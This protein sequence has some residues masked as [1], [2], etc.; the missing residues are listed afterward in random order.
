MKRKVLFILI[1]FIIMLS[2]GWTSS[3]DVDETNNNVLIIHS[4]YQH[5]AWTYGL[6]QGIERNLEKENIDYYLEYL[7]EHRLT[8]ERTYR[9]IY[10]MMAE[11]YKDVQFDCI[12]IADN[13]ALNFMK[14]Y[15]DELFEGV[16]V[17]LVGINNMNPESLFIDDITGVAQ[18]AD[19]SKMIRLIETLHPDLS[20]V[21][22]AGSNNFTSKN[23]EASY[24]AAIESLGLEAKT[25]YVRVEYL[26]DLYEKL[27]TY[28]ENTVVIVTSLVIDK[29][30]T[31]NLGPE[32][33]SNII[34]ESGL[35]V[36]VAV[37]VMMGSE[38]EGAVGG[39]IVDGGVH[40][41]YAAQMV[42][43]I[44]QG[45][46]ASDIPVMWEPIVTPEFNYQR[47]VQ[48]GI[49]RDQLPVGSIVF[50]EPDDGIIISHEIA[51]VYIVV[52]VSLTLMLLVMV[53]SIIRRKNAERA[54]RMN[55]VELEESNT[56]LIKK[57]KEIDFLLNN[58]AITN[59]NNRN[60]FIQ[61]MH[62]L[63]NSMDCMVMY[64][65]HVRN[66]KE[67]DDAYGYHIGDSAR[68]AI[69][70]RIRAVFGEDLKIFA[71]YYDTF[72]IVDYQENACSFVPELIHD[73]E[74]DLQ[75][76]VKVI[77]Y[78][79][80]PKIK[81]GVVK[82]ENGDDGLEL[83]KKADIAILN[84]LQLEHEIAAFYDQSFHKKLE[85][86]L[87]MEKDLKAAIRS[88]AFELYYQPQVN[89]TNGSVQSCEALI[90]WKNADG[91]NVSPAV[92]IPLAEELGLIN[93]I[94]EW[95]FHEACTTLKDWS[96]RGI[97]CS[98]SVNVS[99]KQIVPS[100][101]DLLKRVLKQY[102]ISPDKLFIEI[103]ETA[104]MDDT[105]NNIRILREVSALGIGIALDDFGIGHSSL[106]YIKD[107]PINK[108]KIDKSFIDR[109]TDKE[110]LAIVKA[111]YE[112]GKVF[113]YRVIAEGVETYEQSEIVKKIGIEEIQG[114][115]YSKALSEPS[116]VEYYNRVK[117]KNE[118]MKT[119]V[120]R[121]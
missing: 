39:Y 88:R 65:V 63:L 3:A 75:D 13:F 68:L 82:G 104:V 89:C 44:M 97:N 93:D 108:L 46:S 91:K 22:V 16:P 19:H 69:S 94:G 34:D 70:N 118:K 86:K 80:E 92:F 38:D 27:S 79:F 111:V 47:L 96:D 73:M 66:I 6:Q 26:E 36:Y 113:K 10:E 81:L 43:R 116:F 102:Q 62:D 15:Y 55:Q 71:R 32:Y 59:F 7:D 83:I 119:E 11:K 1:V 72:Y 98:I 87:L 77:E 103:T 120:E 35:P 45:E 29:Q 48:F 23:E 107:F 2:V 110:Q 109:I 60:H 105:H 115:Y 42:N 54:L 20:K 53:Y 114:W 74:L 51:I 84:A 33:I 57:N 85:E 18:T 41:A 56:A 37:D 4:Y 76:T 117:I 21:V 106:K 61:L 40:G 67:F 14:E 101:V 28:D 112:L 9:E 121:T 90:R 58:D 64:A 25:D 5:F 50:G 8:G 49:D 100:L 12:L 17:V 30:R 31:M 78:E 99:A 95:V 52:L 24:K